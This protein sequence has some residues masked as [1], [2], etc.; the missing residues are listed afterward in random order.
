MPTRRSRR[1]SGAWA[2]G[3]EGS[4]RGNVL[5]THWHGLAENDGFRRLL[6]T[7]LADVAGRTGFVVAQDTSF[8][9]ERTRQVDLLADLVEHHLDTS[10]LEHVI[11]HGA[12]PDLPVLTSGLA[13]S[14]A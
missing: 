3:D 11:G 13:A 8:A 4:D 5:G 2:W 7:R 1:G 6:L 9:A 10:S 14:P 12:P